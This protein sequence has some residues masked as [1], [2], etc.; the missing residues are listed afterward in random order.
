MQIRLARTFD[1]QDL[2]LLYHHLSKNYRDNRSTIEA[3]I[4]HPATFV[5]VAEEVGAVVG[6]ATLSVRAVPCEGFVGCVDGVVV[7]PSC[8]GRGIAVSLMNQLADA[9]R[10]LD[11]VRNELTS[12]DSRA[13]AK[14][15]YAKLGYQPRDTNVYVLGL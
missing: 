1:V 15:L 5:Y 7:D 14:R 11:C 6:T 9:A 4:S 13:V 10:Q 3:A 8:R 12:N 2:M